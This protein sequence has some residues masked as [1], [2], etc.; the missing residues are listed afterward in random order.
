MFARSH[1]RKGVPP[2][3]L[4]LS[5]ETFFQNIDRGLKAICDFLG[6]PTFASPP[7]R[8]H[9]NATNAD[10]TASGPAPE[11][12]N[13]LTVLFRDDV[14]RLAGLLGRDFPE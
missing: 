1:Q 7:P 6:V 10:S 14:H 11:D 8:L 3:V 9:L 13:Y 12:R 2:Q 4:C 5:F